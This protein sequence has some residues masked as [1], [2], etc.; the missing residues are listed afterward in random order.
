MKKDE[1]S[2]AEKLLALMQKAIVSEWKP[3]LKILGWMFH[4]HS[5]NYKELYEHPN[6]IIFDHE[7]IKALFGEV[8][9]EWQHLELDSLPPIYG[10]FCT[11]C[12]AETTTGAEYCWQDHLQKAVINKD[13]IGY[14]YGEVFGD[15]R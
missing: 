10:H 5:S 13:P 7:F 8:F 4:M 11:R 12:R 1:L 15:G 3:N 14:M 2:Q 9:H 6:D